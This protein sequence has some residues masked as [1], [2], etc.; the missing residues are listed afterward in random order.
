M[1]VFDRRWSVVGGSSEKANWSN[2]FLE[3][4]DVAG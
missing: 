4:G 3:N 2:F 1:M